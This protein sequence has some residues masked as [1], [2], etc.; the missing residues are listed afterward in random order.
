MLDALIPAGAKSVLD[1][2]CNVGDSLRWA[3]SRGLSV[4]RGVDIN[5]AAVAVA[6]ERLA[7]LGDVEIAHGSADALPFPDA[8]VDVVLCLEVLEH[9]PA[10]LRAAAVREMRRVLRPGGCLIL[11]TPH[12]GL[13]AWLD[14]EN[15]RFRVPA[16]HARASRLVGGAG[17]ETGYAGQ[18][19]GV[20][21]HHHFTMGELRA[22]L[23]E[24]FA[25]RVV[26]GR[27]CF[28]FPIGAA[29]HWPFYRRKATDNWLFRSVGRLMA[30]DYAIRYPLPLA[31]DVVVSAE[32]Y[33]T[34]PRRNNPTSS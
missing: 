4:L 1:V 33:S 29:A 13:F 2:G 20:V 30:F 19:H 31:Y 27:G 22:L 28:L 14:P 12:R 32:P 10:E 5:A 34:P 25:L 11:T 18:K 6:R 9:V 8:S 21:R 16:L 7:P 26:I 23:E 3:H 17:K 24:S 15:L